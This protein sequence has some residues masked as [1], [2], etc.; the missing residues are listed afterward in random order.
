MM[1]SGGKLI[2]GKNQLK[3]SHQQSRETIKVITNMGKFKTS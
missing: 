3:I 1:T 2:I